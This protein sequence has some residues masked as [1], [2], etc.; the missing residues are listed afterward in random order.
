MIPRLEAARAL[1]ASTLLASWPDEVILWNQLLRACVARPADASA[2]M[3]S[4]ET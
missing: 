4:F 3:C 1:M 2:E